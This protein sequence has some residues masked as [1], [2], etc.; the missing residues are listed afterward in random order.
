MVCEVR[1]ATVGVASENFNK[2][3]NE[4]NYCLR[5]TIT[6][7]IKELKFFNIQ[8][9]Q[10]KQKFFIVRSKEFIKIIR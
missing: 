8:N 5:I 3:G 10:L 6:F 1:E 9:H 4:K 7:L 2:N